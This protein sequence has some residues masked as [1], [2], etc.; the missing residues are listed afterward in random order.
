MNKNYIKKII[1]IVKVNSEENVTDN[2]TNSL[3]TVKLEKLRMRY[4][5]C[6]M[7]KCIIQI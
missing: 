6:K 4:V 2:L 7:F 1:D 3:N 5:Y